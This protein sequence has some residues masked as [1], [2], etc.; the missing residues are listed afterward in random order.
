MKKERKARI[1]T[2]LLERYMKDNNLSLS[3]FC[4]ACDISKST[5]YF[6][7]KGGNCLAPTIVKIAVATKIRLSEMIIPYKKDEN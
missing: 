6:L 5:F 3:A 2:D 4:K 1:D 7:K